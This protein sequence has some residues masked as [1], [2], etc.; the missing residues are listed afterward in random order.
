M[1]GGVSIWGTPGGGAFSMGNDQ[2][3]VPA[4]QNIEGSTI[5][6]YGQGSFTFDASRLNSIYGAAN[7][8]QPP[9]ISLIPQ[10]K[11]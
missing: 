2:H 7:T 1:S 4:L 9:A 5:L 6:R 8:V 3:A 10:I 11:Y